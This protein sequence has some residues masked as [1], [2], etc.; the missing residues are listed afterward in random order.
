[1]LSDV[2]IDRRWLLRKYDNNRVLIVSDLH[3]GF[4]VEWFGRGLRV[5]DPTWSINIIKA[6]RK[7]IL[8]IKPSHLVICGDLEHH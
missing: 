4:E 3:L 5:Y 1:M 8:E 2:P 7:D 6:L